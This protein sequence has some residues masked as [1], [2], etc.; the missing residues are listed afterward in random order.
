MNL[1]VVENEDQISDLL[2]LTITGQSEWLAL[3][4]FAMWDLQQRGIEYHIPENFYDRAELEK[5]CLK[6]HAQLEKLCHK[7]DG[8]LWKR[9]PILAEWEIKPFIFQI[10]PSD[11][12]I[13]PALMIILLISRPD[14]PLL[15]VRD[16]R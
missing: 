14:S 12:H 9:F 10:F 5:L 7:L 4:P 3:T 1:F 11:I 8:E 6:R 16:P 15:L 13:S 2:N